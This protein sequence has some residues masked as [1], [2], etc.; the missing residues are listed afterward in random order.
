MDFTS[1]LVK[2]LTTQIQEKEERLLSTYE[3]V[4][5]QFVSHAE[6]I[7]SRPEQ[8]ILS[9]DIQMICSLKVFK[10]QQKLAHYFSHPVQVAQNVMIISRNL[11]AVRIAL[12]HN[13]FETTGYDEKDFQIRGMP[14]NILSAIRLLTIDRDL[15]NDD[16]YLSN[17]YERI[18]AHS[19]DL[20]LIRCLDKFDNLLGLRLFDNL[21]VR[22]SYI[23]LAEKYLGPLSDRLNPAFGRL[24]RECCAYMADCGPSEDLSSRYKEFLKKE[25]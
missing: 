22:A 3:P 19:V 25:F 8:A 14:T 6:K 11:G 10:G 4:L 24:F 15:Q 2:P 9:H 5:K 21:R 20:T 13:L 7:F 1:I 18:V 17:Y 16:T 12:M 23:E